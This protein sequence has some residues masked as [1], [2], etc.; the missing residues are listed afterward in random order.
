[1]KEEEEEIEN[2]EMEEGAL[3]EMAIKVEIA[4]SGT[5]NSSTPVQ[6]ASAVDSLRRSRI[7]SYARK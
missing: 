3:D 7:P 6:T 2:E 1:M 4:L 5:Q